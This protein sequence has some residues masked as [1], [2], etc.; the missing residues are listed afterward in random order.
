MILLCSKVWGPLVWAMPNNF[1]GV[2]SARN[3]PATLP[4]VVGLT[5]EKSNFHLFTKYLST[6]YVPGNV[7]KETE[8]RGF[9]TYSKSLFLLY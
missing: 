3:L 1:L 8:F 9:L 4:K 2:Y 7:H 5:L 6:Y